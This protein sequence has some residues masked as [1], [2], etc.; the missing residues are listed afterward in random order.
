MIILAN[1][2]SPTEARRIRYFDDKV[3]KPIFKAQ[4]GPLS[5]PKD[6][7]LRAIC[8]ELIPLPS[9]GSHGNG[10]RAGCRCR[11]AEPG[12]GRPAPCRP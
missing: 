11:H 2:A 6:K 1:G 12:K 9:T 5:Y 4:T 10:P 3:K 8:G 7:E